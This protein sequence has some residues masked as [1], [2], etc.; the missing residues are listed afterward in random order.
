[1]KLLVCLVLVFAFAAVNA[2]TPCKDGEVRKADCN[3]CVCRNGI[4]ACTLRLCLNRSRQTREARQPECTPGE[5][6]KQDC[7]T[8]TCTSTG[9]LIC[10]KKRCLRSVG[11]EC[12]PGE[13]VKQ[14]C[15]ICQ[16]TSAG[17][18][19]C[20]KVGCPKRKREADTAAFH[21]YLL[22]S[23]RESDIAEDLKTTP[24]APNDFF[25]IDCNTCY[26]NIDR[27]GYLC[28][29]NSCLHSETIASY[30]STTSIPL[31]NGTQ[32]LIFNERHEVLGKIDNVNKDQH[33]V[34]NNLNFS[35]GTAAIHAENSSDAFEP[36][37]T[38]K[39]TEFSCKP[40]QVFHKDCNTCTCTSDG[41]NAICSLK[42]CI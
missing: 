40:G 42:A 13:R 12:T 37:T 15:N 10:T 18:L 3:T 2:G 36:A 7:N 27:S 8:C 29:Q 25:T 31:T 23:K 24:C 16:C 20:P 5:V 41:K 19:V 4:E 28:T 33:Q 14:D 22:R 26:C 34:D 39:S 32:L 6:T 35:G 11:Q 9:I 17:V 1:M 21:E 38:E 30:D